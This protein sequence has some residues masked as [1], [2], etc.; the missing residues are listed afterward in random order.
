MLEIGIHVVDDGLHI[1][2]R[3]L[4]LPQSLIGTGLIL[5]CG[6]NQNPIN[7]FAATCSIF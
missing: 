1:V 4:E 6:C 3:F 7:G 5:Q 2:R